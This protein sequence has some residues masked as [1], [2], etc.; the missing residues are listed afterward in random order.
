MPPCHQVRVALGTLHRR[1][2]DVDVGE[3]DVGGCR[4][5]PPAG[6]VVAEGLEDEAQV[7]VVLEVVRASAGPR[8]RWGGHRSRSSPCTRTARGHRAASGRSRRG[9]C[10]TRPARRR[11]RRV[12]RPGTPRRRH[13]WRRCRCSRRPVEVPERESLP[14]SRRWARRGRAR[15]GACRG[16]GS[17][18]RHGS[19][20]RRRGDGGRWT[21]RWGTARPPGGGLHGAAPWDR[22]P[23]TRARRGAPIPRPGCPTPRRRSRSH[24]RPR[25]ARTPGTSHRTACEDRAPGSSPSGRHPTS[26]GRAPRRVRRRRP[27]SPPRRCPRRRRRWPNRSRCRTVGDPRCRSRWDRCRP[28]VG[29]RLR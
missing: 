27:R 6:I 17:P 5:L 9:C 20:A 1:V 15:A 21:T 11:R 13:R 19:S 3:V 10:C 4:P 2:E 23:G 18:R 28:R 16:R 24:R 26:P 8:S 29:C 7:G 14:A 25:S 22:A 12:G